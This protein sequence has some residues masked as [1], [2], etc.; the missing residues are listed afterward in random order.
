[1]AL[2]Q[3]SEQDR[4]NPIAPTERPT[5]S[6][7]TSTPIQ[8]DLTIQT[9]K[10]CKSIEVLE[11]SKRPRSVFIPRVSANGLGNRY[12]APQS[13]YN[14]L[15]QISFDSLEVITRDSYYKD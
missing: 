15:N 3:S 9:F 8:R 14:G 11:K 5:P 6:A 4:S 2:N 12:S 13:A 10:T 1:M 7:P